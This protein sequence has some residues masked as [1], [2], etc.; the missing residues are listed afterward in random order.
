MSEWRSRCAVQQALCA[1]C[2]ADALVRR[3]TRGVRCAACVTKPSACRMC[4]G[5]ATDG[6]RGCEIPRATPGKRCSDFVPRQRHQSTDVSRYS[7]GSL[8]KVASC[9]VPER[10]PD[11]AIE[12]VVVGSCSSAADAA[13]NRGDLNPGVARGLA[14]PATL[15]RRIRGARHNA[16]RGAC[17]AHV[18]TH[19]EAHAWRTSRRASSRI[20]DAHLAAQRAL[21]APRGALRERFRAHLTPHTVEVQSA[22]PA[23]N[24]RSAINRQPTTRRPPAGAITTRR[25]SSTRALPKN[26]A[27]PRLCRRSS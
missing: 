9:A 24:A 25:T 10:E 6:S 1:V 27:A 22:I 16:F 11:Y 23:A 19:F 26:R 8:F 4:R 3:A 12:R 13:Q 15:W 18:T 7:G 2:A 21:R 17:V 20:C 5:A 14:P